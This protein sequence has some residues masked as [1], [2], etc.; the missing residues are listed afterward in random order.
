MRKLRLREA[1]SLVQDHMAGGEAQL[2]CRRSYNIQTFPI[3]KSVTGSS[4][5][6]KAETNVT[7]KHEVAGS[8]PGLAQWVKAPALPQPV[9]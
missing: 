8:I 2:V 6:G 7:R 5:H 9:V 3:M 1:K 4:P